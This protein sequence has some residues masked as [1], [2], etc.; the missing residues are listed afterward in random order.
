MPDASQCP[1]WAPGA[2]EW[3]PLSLEHSLGSASVLL[4]LYPEPR[5]VVLGHL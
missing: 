4:S 1:E 5:K 3:A 2:S